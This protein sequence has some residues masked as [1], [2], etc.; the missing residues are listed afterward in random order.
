MEQLQAV[1]Y[2]ASAAALGVVGAVRIV[3]ADAVRRDHIAAWVG[4]G[5]DSKRLLVFHAFR[6]ISLG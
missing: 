2:E 4:L 1:H 3:V 5:R 6:C